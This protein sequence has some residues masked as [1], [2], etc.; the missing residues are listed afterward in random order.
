MRRPAAYSSIN[1]S[2]RSIDAAPLS[3]NHSNARPYT[4][5]TFQ[6]KPLREAR[7]PCVLPCACALQAARFN[8]TPS[9]LPQSGGSRAPGPGR[10]PWRR[11]AAGPRCFSQHGGALGEVHS[12]VEPERDACVSQVV[13]TLGDESCLLLLRKGGFPGLLP[14]LVIGGGLHIQVTAAAKQPAIRGRAEAVDMAAKH[15]HELG[16]DGDRP[17]LLQR[18]L[19][20]LVDL[21]RGW[22]SC[23]LPR[24]QPQPVLGKSHCESSSRLASA[25]RIA[26]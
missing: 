21:V 20:N 3:Q 25:G 15:R 18:P 24:Q 26:A 16:R 8:S 2:L 14:G 13:G 9:S 1:A 11:R 4:A 7:D 23:A 6:G 12:G 19:L 17:G 22:I 10:G 5:N